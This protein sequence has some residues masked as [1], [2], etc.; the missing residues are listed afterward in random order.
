M[1][2]L[3]NNNSIPLKRGIPEDALVR[4]A[5]AQA[6]SSDIGLRSGPSSTSPRLPRPHSSH[7]QSGPSHGT[8]S[9]S[10]M[11]CSMSS[12]SPPPILYRV[13]STGDLS[14]SCPAPST[15]AYQS[16]PS[17]VAAATLD[18]GIGGSER[19][20][21]FSPHPV[22]HDLEQLLLGDSA[23]GQVASG[24][25]EQSDGPWSMTLCEAAG[26]LTA[27]SEPT[28]ATC[29]ANVLPKTSVP[30]KATTRPCE[31]VNLKAPPKAEAVPPCSR[32]DIVNRPI[33]CIP[34]QTVPGSMSRPEGLT[35]LGR[36]SYQPCSDRSKAHDRPLVDGFKAA[37]FSVG[38]PSSL[39]A[40]SVTTWKSQHAISIE[41]VLLN[42]K[43]QGQR[44]RPSQINSQEQQYPAVKVLHKPCADFEMQPLCHPQ[45]DNIVIAE[46]WS[47]LQG[48]DDEALGLC[49][50]DGSSLVSMSSQSTRTS[51]VQHGGG[52]PMINMEAPGG[53]FVG[54]DE[55]HWGLAIH[56][57]HAGENQMLPHS[58][59]NETCR[60]GNLARPEI[61]V[62]LPLDVLEC[63]DSFLDDNNIMDWISDLTD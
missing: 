26:W 31:T 32:G 43:G 30:V 52:G 6:C 45:A 17:E 55:L 47:Q 57:P 27:A 46:L 38:N 39:P 53:P 60:P 24:D 29:R 44:A 58:M 61:P 34:E 10:L 51:G 12:V 7:K 54:K 23:G 25:R 20:R 41:P 48:E 15:C 56:A 5:K 37:T 22:L 59:V 14:L 11:S 35:T 2:A 4:P 21:G 40:P 42:N 8:A 9:G 19:P 49:C 18:T 36:C 16:G 50:N 33:A 63:C 1:Q 62:P 13:G 28:P 3:S